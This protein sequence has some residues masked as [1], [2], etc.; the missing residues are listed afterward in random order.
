VECHLFCGQTLSTLAP[1]PPSSVPPGLGNLP[2]PPPPPYALL[3][4]H[5]IPLPVDRFTLLSIKLGDDYLKARDLILFWLWYPG[6][7]RVR[8]DV[9][10]VINVWNSLASQFWEG[11]L[12]TSLKDGPVWFLFE[13]IG[14]TFYGKGFEMIQVLED[15]FRPS[16]ISITF[17][18]L[19]ALFNA[20]QGEKE[21]LHEFRSCFEGH[22]ATLSQ[23]LV[24]ILPIL[25]V[26]LFLWVLHSR[27]HD[28][29]T[30]LTS[31][32]T[33][34][35]SATIDSVLADTQFVMDKFVVVGS[36][37][38]PLTPGTPSCSPAAASVVTDKDGKGYRTPWEWLTSYDIALASFSQGQLLLCLLP[39]Q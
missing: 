24:A 26:I 37:K 12:C 31:R 16:S 27:Y 9:L 5:P 7:S 23:S 22:L 18:T 30:Q 39:F 29:L 10:L 19:L 21:G 34:L 13:K 33:D 4:T 20:T 3:V 25:Q 6:F 8:P 14:S 28:L 36:T 15:N 32:Q 35:A 2:A 1:S 38:K 17:A 11:Q